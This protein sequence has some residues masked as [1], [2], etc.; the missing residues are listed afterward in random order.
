MLTKTEFPTVLT[1][2]ARIATTHPNPPPSTV[3]IPRFI[4]LLSVAPKEKITPHYKL[5][6]AIYDKYNNG[7][8]GKK[9]L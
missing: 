5:Q 8:E 7:C 6:H 2:L 9:D 3:P 4:P 1:R